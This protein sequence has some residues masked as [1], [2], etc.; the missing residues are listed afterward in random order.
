MATTQLPE[1]KRHLFW[2]ANALRRLNEDYNNRVSN[3]RNTRSIVAVSEDIG[4]LEKAISKLT[5]NYNIIFA[6]YKGSRPPS[7]TKLFDESDTPLEKIKTYLDTIHQSYKLL[8][9]DYI[10]R[11]RAITENKYSPTDILVE[12]TVLKANIR[13]L[14]HT[15]DEILIGSNTGQILCMWLAPGNNVIFCGTNYGYVL[16]YKLIDNKQPQL[17]DKIRISRQFVSVD[18]FAINESSTLACSYD[19]DMGIVLVDFPSLL[20]SPLLPSLDGEEGRRGRKEEGKITSL[21]QITETSINTIAYVPSMA[22]IKDRLCYNASH[23]YRELDYET[24]K[25]IFEIVLGEHK[26]LAALSIKESKDDLPSNTIKIFHHLGPTLFIST[27]DNAGGNGHL[28]RLEA[29][30]PNIG[31]EVKYGDMINTGITAEQFMINDMILLAE[32]TAKSQV[33][34]YSHNGRGHDFK[35][36]FTIPINKKPTFPHITLSLSPVITGTSIFSFQ[37]AYDKINVWRFTSERKLEPILIIDI[38]NKPVQ[39]CVQLINV[40]PSSGTLLYT[41]V[42]GSEDS[43]F[44]SQG[45]LRSVSWNIDATGMVSAI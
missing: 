10:A 38:N 39:N 42:D 29:S 23:E 24:H 36:I 1:I 40:T 26:E 45:L 5:A 6:E 28:F 11:S 31:N 2:I 25:T 44:Y 35:L 18:S 32:D 4:I 19:A 9:K 27:Q 13:E 12:L 22:G 7:D 3:S 37:T 41:E 15:Y 30:F 14:G 20:P 17:L 21:N 16:R 34:G 8:N 33:S 43:G